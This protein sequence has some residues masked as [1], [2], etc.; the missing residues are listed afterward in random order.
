MFCN[1]FVSGGYGFGGTYGGPNFF[2]MIPMLIIILMVVYF[3]YKAI[4]SKNFNTAVA[5]TSLSK[6]MAILDERFAK[7]EINEE[8]YISKKNQ[9]Q[10]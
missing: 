10:K 9:L 8:E 4:K 2:M 5:N 1:R 6:A 3:M 7:G